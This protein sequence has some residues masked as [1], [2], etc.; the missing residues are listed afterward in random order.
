MRQL[1]FS[2]ERVL[3]RVDFN[4]PLDDAHHIT[5]DTRIRAA[6]PTIRY[7]LDQGGAVILLSHLGRPLKKLLPD[8]S[9]DKDAYTL[10]HLTDHLST[11]L[12]CPV[13]FTEDCVGHTVEHAALRLKAGEVLLLENTRFHPG[14]EKGD[15]ALARQM[16]ALGTMYINDAFGTAH[17][18]HASTAMIASFFPP[19]RRAFGLLMQAELD[20]AS[21]TMEHPA[22]PLIAIVGGAKVSDKILLLE[23]LLD[24]VDKL[25][26]GGG[27]AYTFMRAQGGMVG[28]SLV[29]E[30]RIG[31]AGTLLTK[32]A[33]KKV[34]LLLPEDSVIADR[35]A[36][37]AETD[38]APSM[39]IPG[40]WMGLDIGPKAR[41]AFA[42]ALR[43]AG[44]LIWNG[45]M[46]VFEMP[47]F[48]EGTKAV[49]LAV[50]EA[51]RNGA[52]SLVGGGD[53]VTAVNQLGLS[54]AVS[55]VSTGG[56][57][58]LELLEGR[59][60]PGVEAIRSGMTE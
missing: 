18:A 37:D 54:D 38:I 12:D 10:R 2:G 60:L 9:L 40:G 39:A 51:T 53:S 1:S 36:V 13:H 15:P 23:S 25:I 21:R 59:K 32:A 5:D 19:G 11:L 26:I 20:H 52:F 55:F 56:G 30:D 14:E 29:D 34:E 44:T 48:A 49:A 33:Q 47:A 22:R 45:P 46:G 4:V 24:R 27:M 41:E 58:M 43:E 16:A 17:R 8:G 50:A 42:A 28:S 35:F 57:A 7:I 6:L 3:V 31:L